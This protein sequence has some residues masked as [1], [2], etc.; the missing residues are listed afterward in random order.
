MTFTPN[1]AVDFRL[2]TSVATQSNHNLIPFR[3]NR[4]AQ[5]FLIPTGL[6]AALIRAACSF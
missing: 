4:P 2:V 5:P 1:L 6:I 3:Y